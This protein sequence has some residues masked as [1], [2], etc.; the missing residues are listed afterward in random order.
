MGSSL[1]FCS[2]NTVYCGDQS[3]PIGSTM[4]LCSEVYVL[5]GNANP[6]FAFACVAIA[7]YP[8]RKPQICQEATDWQFKDTHGE[9][10]DPHQENGVL[11][12][13][14]IV[15]RRHIVILC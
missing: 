12:L 1:Y 11:T 7:R 8:S 9:I 2:A 3:S 10:H 6:I 5:S 13:F 14:T 15:E 4:L